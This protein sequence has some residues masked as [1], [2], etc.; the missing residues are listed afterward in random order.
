MG[1]GIPNHSGDPCGP[2]WSGDVAFSVPPT[3][4]GTICYAGASHPLFR[5]DGNGDSI[6]GFWN[7]AVA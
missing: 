5:R 4:S 3:R 2:L 1:K 6:L 7:S